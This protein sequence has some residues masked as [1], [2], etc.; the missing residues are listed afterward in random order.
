MAAS[1]DPRPPFAAVVCAAAGPATTA[2][3]ASAPMAIQ[4]A[5]MRLLTEAFDFPTPFF[6]V[7]FMTFPSQG[8]GVGPNR[9]DD[10]LTEL[11]EY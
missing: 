1:R 7:R 11:N 6:T 10:S 2:E 4:P 8:M 5:R 9:C 3:A